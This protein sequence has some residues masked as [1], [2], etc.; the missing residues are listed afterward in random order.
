MSG[1]LYERRE[2]RCFMLI[3]PPAS[4]KSTWRARALAGPFTDH[5]SPFDPVIISGDDLIEEECIAKGL[6]YAE[7]FPMYDFKEQK[8]VLRERFTQAISEGRDIV[9]DRT[10]LTVKGRR[11]FLASLP[12]SYERIAV[13]FSVPESVLFERLEKRGI[14]TGKIIPAKVVEDM[15]ATYQPPTSAEFDR[16]IR[17]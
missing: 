5:N 9:I 12:R 17:A 3:G 11:S 13:V 6:T 16:I 8:R 1:R 7:V 14:E 15:I 4:G 2:A 10:N